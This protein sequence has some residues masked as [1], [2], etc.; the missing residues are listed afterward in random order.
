MPDDEETQSRSSSSLREDGDSFG[1]NDSVAESTD[2]VMD[3]DFEEEEVEVE[4]EEVEK[5]ENETG[6]IKGKIVDIEESDAADSINPTTRALSQ[7]SDHRNQTH[8]SSDET[9]RLKDCGLPNVS[10]R[11]KYHCEQCGKNF[12]KRYFFEN[13]KKTHEEG[14]PLTFICEICQ[15]RFKNAHSL[16]VHAQIKHHSSC[17]NCHMELNDS[18]QLL[19]HYEEEHPDQVKRCDFCPKSFLT[20]RSLSAHL[21]AHV[22][23]DE[24]D[25]KTKHAICTRCIKRHDPSAPCTREMS[26]VSCG[27]TF[28]RR[29]HLLDHMLT[30]SE[31]SKPYSCDHCDSRFKMKRAL[32]THV[33]AVHGKLDLI[34]SRCDKTFGS[35]RYLKAH[36]RNIH[37]QRNFACPY[38][39]KAFA[40]SAFLKRHLET[41][42]LKTDGNADQPD[43]G[44]HVKEGHSR[45]IDGPFVCPHYY[46]G[47]IQRNS[48]EEHFCPG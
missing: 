17:N 47:F 43:Y 5:E 9:P 35:Y 27:K 8:G 38:C 34:C 13:H 3:G 11:P 45:A 19:R 2:I 48:F 30:H 40:Q 10:N 42:S 32:D 1:C 37:G 39:D 24:K 29:S 44:V 18:N 33:R 16:K 46:Q 21:K 20:V 14:E 12:E 25:G 28:A 23:S 15:L 6:L 36:E 4:E 26:C 7:G 41:H 22:R 31:K